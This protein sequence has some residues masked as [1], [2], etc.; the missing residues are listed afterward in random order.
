M[1]FLEALDKS[2]LTNEIGICP[3][4]IVQYD[5]ATLHL[6]AQGDRRGKAQGEDTC[7]EYA[8]QP[9][10]RRHAAWHPAGRD[11]GVC[12]AFLSLLLPGV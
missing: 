11:G 2:I 12:M 10:K 4:Q 8:D 3:I 9:C 6:S 7:P 5:S 1:T